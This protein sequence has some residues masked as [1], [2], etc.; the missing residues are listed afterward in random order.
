MSL[1]TELSARKRRM[2]RC[3]IDRGGAAPLGTVL[4]AGGKGAKRDLYW[5]ILNGYLARYDFTITLASHARHA[6]ASR[7]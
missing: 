3:V 6:H 5:L 2:V 7:S 1:R 4:W